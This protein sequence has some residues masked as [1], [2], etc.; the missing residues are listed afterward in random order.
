M[1]KQAL[2]YVSSI[3]D[4]FVEKY[5]DKTPPFG[6]VGFI[7]YKRTYARRVEG[8]ARTEEWFETIQRGVNGLL[9]IGA[10]LTKEEAETLYDKVFN[11]KCSFSGRALWQL[12]TK[13]VDK[14]GGDS[15]M[16][17]WHCCI[18]EP[19]E[20][21]CFIFN[22]LMLGGGVGFN[23]Q[24]E[25]VYEIPKV[26]HDAQIIRKDEKDVDFVV[27]DNREGWVELLRRVLQAFFFTGKSFTYS[28]ICIRGK[29]AP[30]R[31]FGGTASGAEDLCSGID[32]I[33]SVLRARVDKKLRP[34]D[35]LDIA[36]II[37]SVV[38]AGNVRRSAQIALGD[39][40]DFQY[41]DAKNWA[42][43]AIPNWRAMSNNSIICN[44][45]EHL[46]AKFWSGYNGDGEPYGLVNLN[47]CRAYG[48]LADGKNYRPDKRV[49]GVNPCG[50]ICLEGGGAGGEG[51]WESCNLAEIFL[52]NIA[53]AE[54]FK[55]VAEL[56]YKATKT[57]SCLPFIHE[58]T[59]IVVGRNHRLGIGVTGFLQAPHLRDEKIFDAVYKHVEKTD[60]E[61]SKVMGVKPSIK[62]STVKPSGSLSLLAGCTPGV[63]PAYAPYYIRR[64]RMASSDVLVALCK[65]NGYHVEPQRNFDGSWNRDTMV[66]SFPIKT[67]DTAV[68]AKDISAVQQLEHANWLQTHWSDNSVSVTVYY[69][70]DELPAIKEWLS[71]N[72]DQ[73]IKTV[74]FLLHSDHGFV[75]A[76]YE[77]ISEERYNE[78]VA[79]TKPIT[80]IDDKDVMELKDSLECGSG[81]C[82]IK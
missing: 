82:P 4:K 8:Q 27:P 50:E 9:K 55:L 3:S 65:K 45:Y 64:I 12:G 36:N 13:T 63:H 24:A 10:K 73:S 18:N 54:E 43:G 39:M 67:P 77:E 69:R 74:S 14:L 6:P 41:L 2:E 21:F 70:K 19:V 30:I 34:I 28:T 22:E 62:L 51:G 57:I 25:H 49:T 61:Y 1:P 38:V 80:R 23:I 46:P 47:T 79:G 20:A 52:P 72:Y 59:N 78:M 26:K 81:A 60:E 35:C 48:R 32:K 5:K 44:D 7:T 66:V 53:D 68:C 40:N 31:S 15:M 75:Q 16:N 17:C 76:P 58:K 42:K 33:V 56:M 11:L 29:G 37:G 71:K